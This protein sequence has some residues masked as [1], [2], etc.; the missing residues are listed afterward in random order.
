[1]FHLPLVRELNVILLTLEALPRH[2]LRCYWLADVIGY[3]LRH[4]YY[5]A[6][7]AV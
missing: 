6:G 3:W 4:C 1:M 5:A 7:L 2:W